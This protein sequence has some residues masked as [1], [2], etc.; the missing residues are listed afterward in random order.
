[1]DWFPETISNANQRPDASAEFV[2][3]MPFDGG[4]R[5][6]T[7]RVPA[8]FSGKTALGSL[9]KIPLGS[10]ENFGIV[11]K[12]GVVPA[13]A[14]AKK[15]RD[16]AELCCDVPVL[17]PDA[18]KLCEWLAAY[19][20][21]PLNSVLLTILPST[22]RHGVRPV[23]EK[24]ISLARELPPET[25]EKLRRRAKKQA[26]LYEL[27]LS[28]KTGETTLL[29]LPEKPTG[30]GK[31]TSADAPSKTETSGE[32]LRS[33][34]SDRSVASPV[35]RS[36]IPFS[37][38]VIDALIFAGIAKEEIAV[39]SRLAYN[40][41]F[42]GGARGNAVAVLPPD[43]NAEQRAA[44]ASVSQSLSEKKF[45]THLL[46]GVTGSGKTE[47]YIGSIR[48]VLEDGGSAIFLVPEV[49]LTPQTVERLRSRLSDCA[50]Q[51][52]VWHSNLSAG[53]RY[54]AWMAM[55]R[56]EARLLV[57]ARSAIFAPL[58]NLRLI[59]VDEE[60]EPSFKQGETPFYHGRDVAVFRAHL[61]NAVCVLGS[62][63]PSL[64]SF[65]NAR[66]GKYLL[67][68][69]SKRVDDRAFPPMK[70]ID[71]RREILHTSGQTTF[72]RPLIDAL[73]ERLERREQSILFLNRRGYSRAL[74]CPDCG[75]VITCPHCSSALTYHRA[76]E[77]MRCHLCDHVEPAASRCPA[78]GSPKIRWR[79]FGT[80][81]AEEILKNIF[82]DAVA[83]R[84]DADTMSKKNEFRKILSDFRAG[85]IDILLGTQ[86]IAKGLDFPRVT[87]VGILDAD[88]SLHVPDFRA[89]ERTFQLLVQV[90]GRAGRGTLEGEV[91]VQTFTPHAAPIQFAKRADF[92]EFLEDE[93]ERRKEFGYP[94]QRHVIR[95]LFRGQNAELVEETA[96][97]WAEFLEQNAP[98]LCEIRGP[99]PC[100]TE[101]IQDNY[102]FHIW[103][104]CDNVVRAS[105]RLVQLRDA[106]PWPQDVIDLLDV[107]P[108]DVN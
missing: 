106:F 33:R 100:P 82:P 108:A 76:E 44:L 38:A 98:D 66:N 56:G 59:V 80:Q 13:P 29:S 25:L 15:V 83:V 84:L 19:Y 20:A 92:D 58:K 81:R 42:E 60:H 70:I 103:Y 104:F 63:T 74:I 7:Y 18:L 14:W 12:T 91:L 96:D 97:R 10:R 48:K 9:V 45:R 31:G 17:T 16:L 73:R 51:I 75:H 24:Y 23:T 3:I 21:A 55:A 86:M 41:D 43:L 36:A 90:A 64:E 46:H 50:T 5:A 93:L 107:D 72:S 102:R 95:H 30:S 49:A 34:G 2:E 52:V 67:N 54:D 35:K 1:M 39:K 26:A 69:I 89:A 11:W 4:G 62:A 65:Y 85:K 37:A 28:A 78:C 53:E 99:A 101:K 68:R 71:M 94:P 6:Y 79:G 22:V 47:V 8:E 105:S 27:L 61:C 88:L 57:G 87:L 32:N 40:D 77:L